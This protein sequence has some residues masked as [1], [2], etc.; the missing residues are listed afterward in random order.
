MRLSSLVFA[1]FGAAV[2]LSGTVSA[3]DHVRPD[4]TREVLVAPMNGAAPG[5]GPHGL[6]GINFG[7]DGK[8]YGGSVT[9][10]GIYK[11]DVVSETV[12]EVIGAP[13]GEADDVAMAPAASPTPGALVWTALLAGELRAR[14]TDGRIV[15]LAR[16]LP[17]INPVNFTDD[18]R[19][20]VGQMGIPGLRPDALY[21]F[22]ILGR[23]APRLI[24]K[25]MGNINAFVGDSA[26]GLYV[27]L[28][29]KGAVGRIDIETGDITILADGLGQPVAVKR[30]SQG[31]LYAV[32]WVTGR[33][34]YINPDSGETFRIATVPPPVDN[35]A[36]GPDDTIYVSRPSDN[37]IIAVNRNDGSQR[38]V[39]NSGL[40]AP[41]LMTF[42][43][44][45][46][47][48]RLVASD[49]F[50][51]RFIDPDTGAVTLLPFDLTTNAS[52]AVAVNGATIALA[53][54]RRGTMTVID[55][56]ALERTNLGQS[57]GTAVPAKYLLSGFKAP[58][59]IVLDDF[60]AILAVDYVTGELLH[61]APGAASD[62]RVILDGLRGPVGLARGADG[63]LYVTETTS[64]A[65]TRID[66][67]TNTAVAVAMGRNQ[68]E[69]LAALPDG[70]FAVAEA[71]ARRLSIVNPET[72]TIQ[73][74]ADELPIGQMF[75][76]APEPV[77]LPTG[78]AADGDG[79]IY[80]ACDRDNSV[81]KFSP[82]PN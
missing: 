43:A 64:G 60:G 10:P 28:A 79:V 40:A 30:D 38:V 50:G 12:A 36:L 68:P 18:G 24:A 52:S 5:T 70:R 65:L 73:V 26:G 14:G 62:R 32:D 13:A 29:E 17:M 76:R 35:L 82:N 22:D 34:T 27:P 57:G 78:V 55:R 47:A 4:Y 8:L 15:T 67:T 48:P 20:F 63:A 69:G 19:L 66:V 2:A 59:G 51:F 16:D 42:A 49:A 3:Q 71:G 61:V 23:T 56:A 54:V 81:L 72:G 74:I 33:I 45:G 1:G 44:L 25:D 77:Y 39:F 75:T 58:M 6:N 7:S 11:F 37:G 46:G 31:H 80:V 9:G 53:N 41:G 21:E